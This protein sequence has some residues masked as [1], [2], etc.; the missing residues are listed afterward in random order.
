MSYILFCLFSLFSNK[1]FIF[2]AE[3]VNFKG[4][5]VSNSAEVITVGAAAD[6]GVEGGKLLL[7][8]IVE[9]PPL[10]D[11]NRGGRKTQECEKGEESG[12]HVHVCF[13]CECLVCDLEATIGAP[14]FAT[15]FWG[16]EGKWEI[17][18]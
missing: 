5:L 9:P 8:L 18:I 17:K 4:D 15:G 14:D 13:E 16:W 3:V 11:F 1:F 2:F 10:T 12:C 6:E 7:E